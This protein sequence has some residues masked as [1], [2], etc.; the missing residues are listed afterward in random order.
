MQSMKSDYETALRARLLNDVDEEGHRDNGSSVQHGA[1]PTPGNKYSRSRE[2]RCAPITRHDAF[3]AKVADTKP[4]FALYVTEYRLPLVS[5][6]YMTTYR[7]L[8]FVC[9][10]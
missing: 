10:S 4:F 9:P 5:R 1:R 3:A 6:E 7:R 8:S 2:E